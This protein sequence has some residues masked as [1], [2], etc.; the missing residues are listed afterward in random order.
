MF[1]NFLICVFVF[2]FLF[3]GFLMVRNQVVYNI[4]TKLNSEIYKLNCDDMN[5]GI[6][7]YDCRYAW[8]DRLP[9]YNRMVFMF[10]YWSA[11]KVKRDFCFPL[12]VK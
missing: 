3:I 2:V 5:N 11:E 12:T 6:Y 8:Y 4:R 7:N 1:I 9:S 10:T